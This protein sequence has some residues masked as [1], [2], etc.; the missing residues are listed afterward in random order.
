MAEEKEKISFEL[1][2]EWLPDYPEFRDYTVDKG[3]VATRLV[4]PGQKDSVK[5]MLTKVGII[6]PEKLNIPTSIDLRKRCPLVGYQCALGSC[7]ANV[8]VGLCRIL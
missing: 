2:M 7:T 5:A 3:E 8:G 4:R 6:E 1:G